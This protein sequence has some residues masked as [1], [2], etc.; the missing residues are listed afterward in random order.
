MRRSRTLFL[1]ALGLV[2]AAGVVAVTHAPARA[3]AAAPA[4]SRAAASEAATAAGL[5]VDVGLTQVPINAVLCGPFFG[6]GSQGMGAIIAVPTGCGYSV[7]W[8]VFRL[9]G[10]QWRLR[11]HEGNGILKM[12]LV[13]R[14]DGGADIKTTQGFPRRNDPFCFPSR[15]HSAVW[16]W[17]GTTFARGP[18]TVT[19]VKPAKTA[20]PRRFR[21]PSGNLACEFGGGGIAGVQCVSVKPARFAFLYHARGAPWKVG[22]CNSYAAGHGPSTC[23]FSVKIFSDG[24]RITS[25]PV[26]KY[27]K[28]SVGSGLGAGVT[29]SS[30]QAGIT[31]R[32]RSGL[33]FLISRAGIKQLR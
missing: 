3:S 22:V 17:N 32:I 19:E 12:Q 28:Q 8:V 27:G 18:Y 6:S 13:Q 5:E 31:C 25:A 14:S 20:S 24:T 9:E 33:G 4:C 21:S 30:A 7:G 1:P 11:F 15:M 10:D 23:L 26:L 29:C 16:H 2:L